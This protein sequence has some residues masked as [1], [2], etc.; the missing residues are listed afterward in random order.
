M[1]NI[2]REDCLFKYA[3]YNSAKISL[4]TP[5]PTPMSLS[6]A[7]KVPAR[8]HSSTMFSIPNFLSLIPQSPEKDA[9]KG[10]GCITPTIS[11]LLI[12]KDSILKRETLMRK[13]SKNKK[14]CFVWPCLTFS[15]STC[16]SVSYTHLT[17]PT[18]A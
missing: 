14:R 4:L 17:L 11:T 1:L 10:S 2:I 3:T 7:P 13:S 18:K 12:P 5:G 6:S 9:Q 15:S 16:G 8:V